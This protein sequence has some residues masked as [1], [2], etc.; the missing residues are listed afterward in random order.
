MKFETIE[1]Q[2]SESSN[3]F[4]LLIYLIALTNFSTD[5]TSRLHNSHLLKYVIRLHCGN[6]LSLFQPKTLAAIDYIRN[7]NKQGTKLKLFISIFLIQRFQ[8]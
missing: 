6:A 1:S 2:V 4:F 8:I 3:F 5:V 7:V